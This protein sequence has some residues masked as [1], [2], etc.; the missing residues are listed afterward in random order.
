MKKIYELDTE[1]LKLRQ[2]KDE[3]Y[4]KTRKIDRYP[5]K[6]KKYY[7]IKEYFLLT[8]KKIGNMF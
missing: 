5:K 2:W 1:R 7:K 8:L 6:R 3:D 4:Q